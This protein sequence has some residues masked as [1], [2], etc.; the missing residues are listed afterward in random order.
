MQKPKVLLIA[1][2][3]KTQSAVTGA[4]KDIAVILISGAAPPAIVAEY[5]ENAPSVVI[6]AVGP[7]MALTFQIVADLVAAGAHLQ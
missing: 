6:V 2:E 3:K 4:L 1:E 5:T 7:D